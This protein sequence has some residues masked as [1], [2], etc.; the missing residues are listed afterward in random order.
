[1]ESAC[2]SLP[3]AD[4]LLFGIHSVASILRN[5]VDVKVGI[6]R[7]ENQQHH[8]VDNLLHA[9]CS[10]YVC[11]QLHSTALCRW[12]EGKD[13][14]LIWIASWRFKHVLMELHLTGMRSLE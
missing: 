8:S 2:P 12:Q 3:Q 13:W 11:S 6:C 1:M 4:V 14:D 5:G 7:C 9:S 10:M